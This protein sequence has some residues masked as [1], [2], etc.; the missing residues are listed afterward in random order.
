MLG[1]GRLWWVPWPWVL[2]VAWLLMIGMLDER[3]TER[4]RILGLWLIAAGVILA[5]FVWWLSGPRGLER[6]ERLSW[7]AQD[8]WLRR[9]SLLVA[10]VVGTAGLLIAGLVM[11]VFG[12][13]L[14]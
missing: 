13:T 10:A 12:P 7:W 9:G 11:L 4:P 14:R 8:A 5:S 2:F 3:L 6:I 1:K